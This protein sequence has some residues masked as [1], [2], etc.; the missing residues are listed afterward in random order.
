MVALFFLGGGAYLTRFLSL[1]I[2]TVRSA[3]IDAGITP[4][5]MTV[6]L[7][8]IAFFFDFLGFKLIVRSRKVL[9]KVYPPKRWTLPGR[10]SAKEYD[11]LLSY[12]KTYS[13]KT[14]RNIFWSANNYRL[15]PKKR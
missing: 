2:I 10:N 14:V 3:I 11:A 5:Q 12:L 7:R 6:L 1:G 8:Y 15:P 4:Y 13:N 9:E